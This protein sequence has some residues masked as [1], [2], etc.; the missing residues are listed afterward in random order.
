MLARR[1]TNYVP[2]LVDV[3]GS[4]AATL[5]VKEMRPPPFSL[6]GARRRPKMLVNL[7]GMLRY[8]LSDHLKMAELL[9]RN[10]LQHVSDTRILDVK[11]LHPVL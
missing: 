10:V 9:H 5:A 11:R 2:A 7:A 3:G 4:P 8:E 1:S 6:D